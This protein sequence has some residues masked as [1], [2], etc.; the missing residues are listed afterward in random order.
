VGD[1]LLPPAIT[2][3]KRHSGVIN[4]TRRGS[5]SAYRKYLVYATTDR[6]F[7]EAL[8]LVYT[9]D[10]QRP[11]VGVVYEVELVDPVLD[12]DLSTFGTSFQARRGRIV[13]G[14]HNVVTDWTRLR[15]VL[16]EYKRRGREVNEERR[17]KAREEKEKT[18]AER[19]GRRAAKR[20]R[21]GRQ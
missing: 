12:E 2:G 6:E 11:G 16:N 9:Q 18:K 1:E 19:E 14:P 15:D 17:A 5:G 3:F 7:A 21:K 4:P 10:D 20:R 13:S 8:A